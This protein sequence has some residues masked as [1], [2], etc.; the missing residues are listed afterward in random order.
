MTL[1]NAVRRTAAGV[2]T[3]TAALCLLSCTSSGDGGLGVTRTATFSS[4]IPR[5]PPPGFPPA[6]YVVL[7]QEGSGTGTLC[8]AV[9]VRGVQNLYALGFTVSFDPAVLKFSSATPGPLLGTSAQVLSVFTPQPPTPA[10]ATSVEVGV[11]RKSPETTG[12]TGTG[13]VA[14]LCFDVVGASAGSP[15]TFTGT[16]TAVQPDP[17]SPTGLSAIPGLTGA[18]KWLGGTVDAQ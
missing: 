7:I 11:T 3:V 18:D 15:V 13:K 8:L 17:T 5:S 16:R 14:T 10:T 4:I 6:P 12:V 1:R 2:L 9:E